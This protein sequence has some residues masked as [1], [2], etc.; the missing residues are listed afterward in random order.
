MSLLNLF[1]VEILLAVGAFLKQFPRAM[2]KEFV[3]CYLELECT[4]V[5][6]VVEFHI[7]GMNEGKF[8]IY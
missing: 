4:T 1:G 2:T 3:V 6:G 8:L 5:P 7:I